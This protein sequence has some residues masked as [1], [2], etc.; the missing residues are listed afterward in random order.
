VYPYVPYPALPPVDPKKLYKQHQ[1]KEYNLLGFA[2]FSQAGISYALVFAITFCIILPRVWNMILSETIPDLSDPMLFLP[3]W[4]VPVTSLVATTLANLIPS[5]AFSHH[6]GLDVGDMFRP[7]A[8][9]L[10]VVLGGA[11]VCFA[12]NYS[13]SFFMQFVNWLLS[14]A[15]VTMTTPD[16]SLSYDTAGNAAMLFYVVIGAPLTEELLFRG[17]LLRTLQRTGRTFAIVASALLF[18]MLHGNFIQSVPTFFIGLVLGYVAVR[19]GSIL[20]GILIHMINNGFVMALSYIEDAAW[21]PVFEIIFFLC[22]VAASAAVLWKERKRFPLLSQHKAPKGSWGLFFSS[23]AILVNL[24]LYFGMS[25]L[26]F[27]AI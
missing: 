24:I 22:C 23:W 20:P 11:A 4:A 2:L 1:R 13:A 18:A 25:L 5:L 8:T 12:V 9:S 17:L 14:F 26:F 15:G 7:K 6:L 19:C 27:E 3:L 21:L 10:W 16:V